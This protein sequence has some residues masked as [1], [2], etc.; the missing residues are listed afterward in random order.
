MP[1]AIARL[2]SLYGHDTIKSHMYRR[3]D[4][5]TVFRIDPRGRRRTASRQCRVLWFVVMGI[6]PDSYRNSHRHSIS[7]PCLVSRNR[8]RTD[9]LILH[10][11][12]LTCLRAYVHAYPLSTIHSYLDISHIDLTY[13]IS[14]WGSARLHG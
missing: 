4:A 9:H 13:M 2:F 5:E 10:A 11:Y 14:T 12:I 1:I 7:L 3:T 8:F 6:S